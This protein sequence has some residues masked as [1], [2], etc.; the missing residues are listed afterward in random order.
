[1][2]GKEA[3]EE[4][5]RATL[6]DSGVRDLL[7]RTDYGLCKSELKGIHVYISEWEG[8]VYLKL[9]DNCNRTIFIGPMIIHDEFK[10]VQVGIF[11]SQVF[12]G[13]PVRL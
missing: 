8:G 10:I 4:E 6:M 7:F 12:K 11:T 1:M 5:V 13:L 2:V 9:R 3:E